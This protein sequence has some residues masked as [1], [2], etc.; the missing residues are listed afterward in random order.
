MHD[1]R[2]L[3]ALMGAAPQTPDPSFRLEVF[4]RVAARAQRRAALKRAVLQLVV[5]TALGIMVALVQS[6]GADAGA[7]TPV[8]AAAGALAVAGAFA[9]T[10]ITGPKAAISRATMVLRGG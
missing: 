8:L 3:A 4:A 6:A 1:D 2:S 7:W 5:F 10:V 9:V